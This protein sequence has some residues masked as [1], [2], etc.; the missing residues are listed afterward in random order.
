MALC[1]RSRGRFRPAQPPCHHAR[2]RAAGAVLVRDGR[3]AGV[4]D[5][6]GV[7]AGMP[8]EDLGDA[9]LMPGLVDT[10]VH[11]NEPG[12]TEW[13]GF[14]TATRAAAAG[15]VTTLVDMPLNCIPVTTTRDALEREARGGGGARSRRRRLLGRRRARQRRR[16]GGAAR[17][18]RAA[19]SRRSLCHSGVDEF[20]AAGEAEL[21]AAMPILR[22]RGVPLL[23]HAELAT[24]AR[25][26]RSG[27]PRR[28]A[29]L[30][31]VAAAALGARGDR[32]AARGCAASSRAPI[33]HR[34][35]LGGDRVPAAGRGAREGLPL[36]AETCPHYL[37]RG[38]GR[39]PTARTE[40]KC[41]PPI[42]ERAEPRSAVGRARA[43]GTI[44]LVV[45]DHSP[46][47]PALKAPERGDFV[48]RLG[49]HR[50][51]P[52]RAA[53]RLDRGAPARAADSSGSRAGWPRRPR[54]LAGLSA[55][56]GAIAPGYDA[57]LVVF[58]PD[59]Q[60][61]GRTARRSHHRHK[62]TP[63]VGRTLHG[64]VRR[65]SARRARLRQRSFEGAPR[66]ALLSVSDGQQ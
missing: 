24:D 48:A 66:G 1:P 40:F 47:T 52:A 45:S 36:T 16:A 2:G 43:S 20:P 53:G 5:A 19:A 41:A 30:P 42:R 29:T 17:R 22:E 11:V 18:R 38:R 65:R 59:A 7:P 25:P 50:L 60:L 3:I 44:D 64:V 26:G 56:K 61:R 37:L 49:R 34:A 9:V 54:A 6:G 35:S 15:G 57:D 63:Y 28:Y 13:E 10:H 4:V 27:D 62:L 12:R 31:R 39:S 46:C 8:I 14:E 32:A 21:R 23:V 58:D 55:S 33:A 51:A